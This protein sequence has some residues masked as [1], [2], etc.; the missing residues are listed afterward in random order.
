MAFSVAGIGHAALI[1][2][3]TVESVSSQNGGFDRLAVYAVNGNGLDGTG[4]QHSNGA[5]GVAWMANGVTANIV[6]DLGAE[7]TIDRFR[8]WNYNEAAAGNTDRGINRVEVTYGLTA[9]LGSTLAGVTNFARADGTNT[10]TGEEFNISP[11]TA[12]Y[13][14]FD[15]LSNYG[16]GGQIGLSEVQFFSV[17]PIPEPSSVALL[18]LGAFALL[19]RR[20]K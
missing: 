3:I 10:Y 12:R 9:G 4:T 20:R 16:D 1:S 6:F 14:K 13:I 7:Y 15:G 18:G 8:V 2:P 17:D 5:S 11:I 19:M